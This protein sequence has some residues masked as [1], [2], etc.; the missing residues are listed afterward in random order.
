M[1]PGDLS[2]LDTGFVSV[3]DFF[4]IYEYGIYP[5]V[6]RNIIYMRFNPRIRFPFD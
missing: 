6:I 2:V 3:Q 5:D 1:A 4:I